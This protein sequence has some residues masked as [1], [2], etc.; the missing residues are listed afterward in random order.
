M[1]IN[2]CFDKDVLYVLDD[3]LN[4]IRFEHKSGRLVSENLSKMKNY[5][6]IAQ[7]FK[8]FDMG[9][10]YTMKVYKGMLGIISDLG[11]FILDIG[12]A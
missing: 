2:F 7:E 10:S 12:S 11:L 3:A 9:Y 6:E 1:I 8:P 4:I 5:P